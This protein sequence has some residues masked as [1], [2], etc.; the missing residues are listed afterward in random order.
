MIRLIGWKSGEGLILCPGN[1]CV[2]SVAGGKDSLV[3][4]VFAEYGWGERGFF[5][6]QK[7]GCALTVHT[8]FL[9]AH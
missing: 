5:E 6:I 7:I 3:V 1:G 9:Q 8:R 4:V 2:S